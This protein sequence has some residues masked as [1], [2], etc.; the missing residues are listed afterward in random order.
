MRATAAKGIPVVISNHLTSETRELYRGAECHEV[1]VRR[2]VTARANSRKMVVEGIFVFGS[3]RVT[4]IRR[5]EWHQ[6]NAL[7]L[8]T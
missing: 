1:E 2:S 5:R 8:R 4:N 7:E 3:T 6:P